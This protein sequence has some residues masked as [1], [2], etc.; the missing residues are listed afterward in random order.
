M[1]SYLISHYKGKYR[2][3]CDICKDTNDFPKKLDG[4]Y[5]DI[6]CYITCEK[7]IKIFH[8]GRGILNCYIPSIKQGRNILRFFYRDNINESN[9]STSVNEYTIEKD[10]KEINMRKETI[11][12]IDENLFREELNNNKFIF[13]IYETD[14][15]VLFKFKAANMELL[16]KYLNPKT[17]GANISPFSVKNRPKSSY[18]IPDEDLVIYKK[19]VENLGQDNMFLLGRYVKNFLQSLITKKNTYED[20][21]A[22]MALK[23][24]KGKEY[25]HSIGKWN[26]YI[27]YL[28]EQLCQN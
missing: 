15:E 5:E 9:T 1:S 4:T 11:S 23:G 6:D 13:D 16:E 12:I 27:K 10:G 8:Y 20:I 7:G 3:L 17:S 18:N 19:I 28:E 14:E 25:I 21:K 2:I 26:E 22:D 24:L